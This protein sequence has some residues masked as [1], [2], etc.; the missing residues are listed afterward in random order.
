MSRRQTIRRMMD[1]ISIDNIHFPTDSDIAH[2]EASSDHEAIITTASRIDARRTLDSPVSAASPASSLTE[3][4]TPSPSPVMTTHS[5]LVSFGKQGLR[6]SVMLERG[7]LSQT[8]VVG[9]TSTRS[10]VVPSG[11]DMTPPARPPP[12][13]TLTNPIQPIRQETQAHQSR[14]LPSQLSLHFPARRPLASRV[15]QW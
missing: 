11:S 10:P 14:F 12:P 6:R 13:V 4:A 5:R 9:S 7:V 8:A 1:G 15:S 3:K 2:T